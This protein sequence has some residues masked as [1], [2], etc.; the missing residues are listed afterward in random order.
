MHQ[1]QICECL[2]NALILP[3]SVSDDKLMEKIRREVSRWEAIIRDG[4]LNI[5]NP[6]ATHGEL[7]SFINTLI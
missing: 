2:V 5:H 4:M 3:L 1:M 6:E 7:F